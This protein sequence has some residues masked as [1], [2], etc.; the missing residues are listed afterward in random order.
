MAALLL[1][2]VIYNLWGGWQSTV[3]ALFYSALLAA[4]IHWA[5]HFEPSQVV[6]NFRRVMRMNK[7]TSLGFLGFLLLHL[8]LLD[9]L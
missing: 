9:Y 3:V 4:T 8:F 7:I 6:S 2:L 5:F 1:T